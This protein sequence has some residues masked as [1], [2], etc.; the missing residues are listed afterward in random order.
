MQDAQTCS[1]TTDSAGRVDADRQADAT[2]DVDGQKVAEFF[3]S[4]DPL[5]HSWID[6]Q[7]RRKNI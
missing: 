3:L 2:G 7:L 6:E 5:C 1:L 4:E